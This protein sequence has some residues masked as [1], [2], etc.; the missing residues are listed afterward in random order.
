MGFTCRP[1]TPG[2]R[3]ASWPAGDAFVLVGERLCHHFLRVAL[4]N[5]ATRPSSSIAR[6]SDL[7]DARDAAH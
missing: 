4:S 5:D 2:G 1:R 7:N 6:A 3:L